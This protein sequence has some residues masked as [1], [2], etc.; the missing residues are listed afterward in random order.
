MATMETTLSNVQ[1][2]RERVDAVLASRHDELLEV[3][4]RC[5]TEAL[6]VEASEV[7]PDASLTTALA[8]ESLDYVDLVFRLEKAF[9]IKIPRN[10]LI[11]AVRSSLDGEPLDVRG[12]LT[13]SA[14]DRLRTLMPEVDASVFRDG[15]M[16]HAVPDLFTVETFVRLVA[17][18]LPAAVAEPAEVR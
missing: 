2:I 7:V 6:G 18:H 11:E 16:T 12:R 17:W 15:L 1:R 14:L 4:R 10:G 3:V 5:V 8:A 13:S 9:T